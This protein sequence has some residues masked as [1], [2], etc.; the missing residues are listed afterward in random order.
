MPI[1]DSHCHASDCWYEPV[2]SLLYQMDANGVEKAILIQMVGQYENSYQAACVRRYPDRIASVVIVDAERPDAVEQLE[3][4]KERGAA[5]VRFRPTTRSPGDDPFAIW[6]A[7][8]R[9]GLSVSCGGAAAEFAAPGLAE[10]VASVPT[11]KIVIEHLGSTSRPDEQVAATVRRRVLGLSRYPNTYIKIHGLGEF[12]RRAL[13]V[14]PGGPDGQPAFPFVQP[15]PNA[16]EAAYAA[17][18]AGRMMWGSDFPPVSGREGY[19]NALRLP[20]QALEAKSDEERSL[21]FGQVA[22]TVFSA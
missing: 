20:M 8:E 14:P 16:L 4:E 10:I 11:L 12:C 18:G 22:L 21:I 17:F 9:L 13:P 15:L 1:V 5:G 3:R 7:A 19:R 6:R 2:E